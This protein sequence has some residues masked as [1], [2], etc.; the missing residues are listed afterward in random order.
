MPLVTASQCIRL[1]QILH[2]TGL[3]GTTRRRHCSHPNGRRRVHDMLRKSHWRCV[4]YVRTHV[5]VLRMRATTVAGQRGRPLSLMPGGN[6]WRYQDIQIVKS[7]FQVFCWFKQKLVKVYRSKRYCFE[8]RLS[9]VNFC[10]G[11]GW[12]LNWNIFILSFVSVIISV[13]EQWCLGKRPMNTW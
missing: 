3:G 8:W 12:P 2:A 4:V 5:H 10:F 9:L 1:E 7:C 6:P 11:F 13:E